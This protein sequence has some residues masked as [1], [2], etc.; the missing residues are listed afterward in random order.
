MKHVELHDLTLTGK[1]S[2]SEHHHPIIHPHP[3]EAEHTGPPSSRRT[4]CLL[5][6]EELKAALIPSPGFPLRNGGSPCV[7]AVR[8]GQRS[9]KRSYACW[10]ARTPSRPPSPSARRR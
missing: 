1:V 9:Q 6:R 2:F 5:S 10:E 8:S 7:S 4:A 3:G